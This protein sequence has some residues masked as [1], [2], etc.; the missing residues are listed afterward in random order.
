MPAPPALVL[1]AGDDGSVLRVL[2]FLYSSLG[3]RVITAPDPTPALARLGHRP[4]LVVLDTGPRASDGL[5]VLRAVKRE[6]PLVLVVVLSDC[7]EPAAA[8]RSLDAGADEYMTKPFDPAELILR[9]E[10]ILRRYRATAA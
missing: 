1:A 4:A 7:T 9:S 6:Q 5:A 2:D 10:A 3:Y 8:V